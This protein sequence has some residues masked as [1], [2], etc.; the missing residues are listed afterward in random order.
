MVRRVSTALL[1]LA[2]PTL[3]GTC[4]TASAA[5]ASPR[6]V[7]FEQS[8]SAAR[9]AAA[10]LRAVSA[11]GTRTIT[12]RP[13]SE[14]DL[15]GFKWSGTGA[16]HIDVRSYGARGWS[17]WTH[18]PTES[19]DR[20]DGGLFG[21]ERDTIKASSP[22]WTGRSAEL[23]LRLEGTRYG[24]LRAHYVRLSRAAASGGAGAASTGG[25]APGDPKPTTK[26]PADGR[27]ADV[28]A[29]PPMVT[30]EGRSGGADRAVVGAHAQGYN[31][32]TTGISLVGTF[33]SAA[34]PAATMDS[35]QAVLK[36]KLALAG[37]TRNE[38]VP[39][40]STGGAQNRFKNGRTVFAR[41]ISGHRDLGSTSC[42]GGSAYVRLTGLASYLD[43]SQRQAV[44]MSL[45]LKRIAAS[46]G[47]QSVVVSGRLRAGGAAING[48]Q[49]EIQ[50]FNPGAGWE[51]I[52]DATS[53][54]NGVWQ[55]T[56]RPGSRVYLRGYFAGDG[57]RRVGRSVWQFSPKLKKPA[58]PVGARR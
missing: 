25:V 39:L 52:A 29:A 35:L 45:R 19:E 26:R 6:V 28:P 17:R 21:A 41:V 54:A 27:S 20:P 3:A 4:A 53:N 49:V 46:D 22:V 12:L 40:I 13:R 51:K 36:W 56:V 18:V 47:G 11:A 9:P 2:A 44:R 1:L 30:Y 31:G 14:F 5:A 7:D 23:Q 34:P 57:S 15:V 43:Q 38:R 10:G 48:G 55:A 24:S 58:A 8:V 33:T 32:Q 37:I 50:A 16:P 42:P